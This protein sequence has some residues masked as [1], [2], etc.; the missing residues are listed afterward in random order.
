MINLTDNQLE[1]V[2]QK[3]KEKG[4]TFQPLEEELI[5]HYACLIE[6][7]MLKG[8]SF[9]NAFKTILNKGVTSDI[10]AIQN[11]T[12]FLLTYKSRIMKKIGW[13]TCILLIAACIIF[14]I[15]WEDKATVEKEYVEN[16]SIPESISNSK[17][18]LVALEEPPSRSPLDN[19]SNITSSF[20][21]RIHPI[22]KK[23]KLHRGIDFRAPTGTPVYATADGLVEKMVT[24][25]GYGK[26][27]ILKH[28]E[29]YQTYYAQLSEFEVEAGQTVKKG[30]LIGRVGSSGLSTAP[31]LHYEVLKNG[32]PVNPEKYL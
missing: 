11:E 20:G 17:A 24:R 8:Q 2:C 4:L 18:V 12:K 26:L 7:E 16:N 9:D 15:N 25:H 3:I 22:Y 6:Q 21:M 31:H 14:S 13:S 29:I 5:D 23:E 32:Q 28:D 1:L 10:S 19:A 30:D 27:I